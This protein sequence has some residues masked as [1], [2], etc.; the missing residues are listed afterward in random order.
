MADLTT[1]LIEMPVEE[2][3]GSAEAA[4]A[5]DPAVV[6][7][8]KAAL[9]DDEPQFPILRIEEGV[10]ANDFWWTEDMLQSVMEQVNT[11]SPVAYLG[12]IKPEDIRYKFPDIQTRWLKAAMTKEASRQADR[13]GQ[14]VSVLW[15]KG[16]NLPRTKVRDYIAAKIRLV[17]SWS[18]KA[19]VRFVKQGNRTVKRPESF[20]LASIDWARPGN[21]AM[22]VELAGI[23]NEMEGSEKVDAAEVGKLTRADLERDNPNLVTLLVNEGKD[24]VDTSALD[25]KATKADEAESMFDKL[26]KMLGIDANASIEEAVGTLLVK[27]E[28]V[29]RKTLKDRVLAIV[30]GKVK[31][32]DARAGVMRL[33]PV[34]EMADLDD[35]ALTKRVDDL[36]NEDKTIQLLVAEMSS[37]PAPLGGG[38]GRQQNGDGKPRTSSFVGGS[39]KV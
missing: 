15:I 12:H 10:S 5:L 6:E 11:D 31:D 4:V 18:G 37:G 32:D 13:L 28:E 33:L 26:R 27:V 36:F 22:Q 19:D 17:T 30:S 1:L 39:T 23:V 38:R 9:K 35:D 8:L 25:A 16:Y 20:R 21:A 14:T 7:G 24:S 29:G 34:A 2:M 3:A